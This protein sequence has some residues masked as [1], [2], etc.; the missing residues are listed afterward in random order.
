LVAQAEDA[1]TRVRRA[2]APV[3]GATR[4][5]LPYNADDPELLGWV[6]LALIDSLA[7]SVRRFGRTAFDL[8]DYLAETA[9]IGDRLSAAHVPHS[10]AELSAVKKHYLP[11]LAL[12]AETRRAHTFLLDPPLPASVRL[13][14]RVVASAA[15][16]AS[17][18]PELRRL[19]GARPAL[20]DPA[21]RLVGRALTA[22]LSALLGP[23][24]AATAAARRTARLTG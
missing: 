11:F 6:H 23:S 20:P 3:R 2:H 17:L 7:D 5:G 1:C 18:P 24:S 22:L 9:V 8:D 10:R 21:A 19:L 4:D 14:Y 13:P 12:T 16:A 15:A